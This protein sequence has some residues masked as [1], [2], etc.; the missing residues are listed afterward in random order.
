[1][2]LAFRNVNLPKVLL[3]HSPLVIK[4]CAPGCPMVEAST[5]ILMD[6]MVTLDYKLVDFRITMDTNL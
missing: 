4:Q 1:M 2:Y 6:M 3:V 5:P